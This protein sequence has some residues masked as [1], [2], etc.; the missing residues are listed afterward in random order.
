MF[1]QNKMTSPSR[2]VVASKE[3]RIIACISH[4]YYG[5]DNIDPSSVITLKCIVIKFLEFLGK[6]ASIPAI[7]GCIC[8]HWTLAADSA[9][10][11]HCSTILRRSW[12]SVCCACLSAHYLK[13]PATRDWLTTSLYIR[14]IRKFWFILMES[15][16]RRCIVQLEAVWV[17]LRTCILTQ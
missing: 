10:I 2:D 12:H 3:W 13:Q 9:T 7:P 17:A 14:D 1:K 16:R 15:D 6:G 8:L 5:S 11:G 4:L